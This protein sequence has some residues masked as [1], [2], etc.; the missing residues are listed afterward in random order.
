MR[1]AMLFAVS[2]LSVLGCLAPITPMERLQQSANDVANALRF[3]RTDLAAE[4]CSPT[5][6]ADFLARHAVWTDKTRV[7]DLELSGIYLRTQDEAEA[8]VSVSW[9]REDGSELHTTEISQRWKH[10][11]G[12]FHLVNE[13]FRRGDKS[14][15]EMIPKKEAAAKG[16]PRKAAAAKF[17]AEADAAKASPP[18]AASETRV[19]R[20]D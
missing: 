1:V 11:N 2:V 8:I 7:L 19:I 12:T 20:A 18:Q 17:D 16:D 9:Q 6:R 13:V 4:F 14:L 10:E 5:A 15:F 3:D